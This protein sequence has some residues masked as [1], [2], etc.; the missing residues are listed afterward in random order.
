MGLKKSGG[1]GYIIQISG[2]FILC[3]YS[4]SVA[5]AARDRH[6]FYAAGVASAFEFG[7]QKNINNFES[8]FRSN[9]ASGQH[10]H[11]GV[12][13]GTCQASKFRRPA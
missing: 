2:F 1:L 6:L 11:I 5:F 10:K 9:E 12:V 4:M 8:G 13:V 7:R 3:Q